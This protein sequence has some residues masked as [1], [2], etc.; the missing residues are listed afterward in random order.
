MD[1]LRQFLGDQGL[2]LRV[3]GCQVG[4][5]SEDRVNSG[6]GVKII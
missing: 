5:L 2:V 6:P 3:A 4:H 1:E